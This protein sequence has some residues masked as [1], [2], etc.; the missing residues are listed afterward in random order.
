MTLSTNM[1]KKQYITYCNSSQSVT[2][3][4]TELGI[5]FRAVRHANP[6]AKRYIL[7]STVYTPDIGPRGGACIRE[8]QAARPSASKYSICCFS[9]SESLS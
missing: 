8:R 3:I 5:R 1:K 4:N 7:S 6:D 2:V 9:Y